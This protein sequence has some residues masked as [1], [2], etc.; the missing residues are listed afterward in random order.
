MHTSSA[1]F[2]FSWKNQILNINEFRVIT[3]STQ[4][5][6]EFHVVSILQYWPNQILPIVTFP[7]V[8]M[9]MLVE[10]TGLLHCRTVLM[11]E[12]DSLLTLGNNQKAFKTS[13]H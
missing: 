8:F 10:D 9:C 3:S 6:T 11:S 7:Y 1:H 13:G 5:L 4:C 2:C 12:S